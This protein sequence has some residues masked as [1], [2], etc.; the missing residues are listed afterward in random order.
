MYWNLVN[1]L[2]LL[3][4]TNIDNLSSRRHKL[5]QE[6]FNQQITLLI[7]EGI[8]KLRDEVPDKS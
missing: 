6:D 1:I 7:T 4:F 3:Q 5:K 2:D 8:N